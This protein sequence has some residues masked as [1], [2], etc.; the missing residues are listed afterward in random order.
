MT[1]PYAE[2]HCHSN[3]SFLDGASHPEELAAEAARLGLGALALTDHDGLYG[4]VRFAAAAEHVGLG[5]V[6][7]A[8]LTLAPDGP[9]DGRAPERTGAPD[10]P[11]AHLLVLARDPVGYA[12][13]SCAIAEAQLAGGEKGRP[14][15]TIEDLAGR[16][17]GHWTVLTGCRKGAAP[18][19]SSGP[20]RRRRP[21]P[22]T[23]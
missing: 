14:A 16:H 15:C 20:A 3:F 7:G 10:P 22:S 9:G 19:R 21:V 17:D 2:L 6:F 4:V 23:G 8:E 1:E 5:T 18:P 13:L 11:G 12:R